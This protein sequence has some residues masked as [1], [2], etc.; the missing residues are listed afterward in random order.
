MWS[1]HSDSAPW[2]KVTRLSPQHPGAALK[3]Q[4]SESCPDPELRYGE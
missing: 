1:P 2:D 4:L 3:N